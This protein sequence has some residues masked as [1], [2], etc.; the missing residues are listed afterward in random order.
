MVTFSSLS[1]DTENNKLL[2]DASIT[3]TTEVFSKIYIDTQ[4]DFVCI[5]EPSETAQLDAYEIDETQTIDSSTDPVDLS[6]FIRKFDVDNDLFFVFLEYYD[7][8]DTDSTPSYVVG[9]IFNKYSLNDQLLEYVKSSVDGN[10][11]CNATCEAVT[12]FLFKKGFQLALTNQ[13]F[14]SVIKYWKLLHNLTISKT[15][16]CHCNG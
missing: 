13:D 3:S 1:L 8:Q 16:S 6:S 4:C 14:A 7:P 12:P 15:S 9:V 2:I 5:N 11:G 10:C